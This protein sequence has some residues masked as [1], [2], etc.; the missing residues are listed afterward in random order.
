MYKLPD[1]YT[2]GL[3]KCL[4]VWSETW[5]PHIIRQEKLEHTRLLSSLQG[6]PQ[7]ARTKE[8]QIGKLNYNCMQ[9]S[10]ANQ[11]HVAQFESKLQNYINCIE[12]KSSLVLEDLCQPRDPIT[13]TEPPLANQT[14]IFRTYSLITNGQFLLRG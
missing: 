3:V 14:N 4:Q 10:T 11:G 2:H 12:I 8:K 6:E 5:T 13:T 7:Q 1:Q 9:D